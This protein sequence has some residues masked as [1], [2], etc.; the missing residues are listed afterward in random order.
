M[1][2]RR[3][4]VVPSSA[5]RLARE[6][7]DPRGHRDHLLTVVLVRHGYG[8]LRAAKEVAEIDTGVLGLSQARERLGADPA[9]VS[10]DC[11]P[12]GIEPPEGADWRVLRFWEHSDPVNIADAIEK[13]VRPTL[14]VARERKSDPTRCDGT[15][16]S[17]PAR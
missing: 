13:A 3:F 16:E 6:R 15:T 14:A 10:G 12:G 11:I 17:N 5:N 9:P 4:D 7:R 1:T 2:P 8:R